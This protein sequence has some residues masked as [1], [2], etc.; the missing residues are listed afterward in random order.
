MDFFVPP[1][2]EGGLP[3]TEAV[4]NPKTELSLGWAG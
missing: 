4:F 2:A 1:L 3:W